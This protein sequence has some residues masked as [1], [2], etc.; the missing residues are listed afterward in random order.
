MTTLNRSNGERAKASTQRASTLE[1]RVDDPFGVERE[2]R[3][4]EWGEK[5]GRGRVRGGSPRE[6]ADI[7]WRDGGKD[8]GT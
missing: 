1:P 2:G 7:H 3:R 6:E 8:S 5:E 4:K